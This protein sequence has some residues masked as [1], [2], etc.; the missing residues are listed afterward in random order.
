MKEVMFYNYILV[1]NFFLIYK[2]MIFKIIK[3]ISK[4]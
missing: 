2:Q 3:Y 1:Y 4:T